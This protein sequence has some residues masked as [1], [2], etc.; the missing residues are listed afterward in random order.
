ML[1][2]VAMQ[3]SASEHETDLSW[4]PPL[5]ALGLR[6]ASQ[7][8]PSHRTTR[9]RALSMFPVLLM[10]P[11]AT[12]LLWEVHVTPAKVQVGSGVSRWSQLCPSNVIVHPD[13]PTIM[14]KVG[15][16]H[17]TPPASPGSAVGTVQ[18]NP[19][20]VKAERPAA[21]QNSTE[22]QETESMRPTSGEDMSHHVWPSQSSIRDLMLLPSASVVFPTAMHQSERTQ[23]ADWSW[24]WLSLV[25]NT[26]T[27]DVI[28]I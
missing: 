14:Q 4:L 19:S 1:K 8:E 3:K 16:V 10:F 24:L 5:A 23:E 15:D 18:A 28:P 2:P 9:V 7:P 22:V 13:R 6:S 27:V 11:T 21:T 26:L 20:Q 25:I 17:W 12:Q